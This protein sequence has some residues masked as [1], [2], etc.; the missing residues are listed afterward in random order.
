MVLLA[1]AHS[2]DKNG[3]AKIT[4]DEIQEVLPI[5]RSKVAAGLRILSSL[6]VIDADKDRQSTYRLRDF[7]GENTWAK[8]PCRGLYEADRIK[9]LKDFKLRSKSEL[10]AMKLYFLFAS[11]RDTRLNETRLSHLK[12]SEYSG[13]PKNR[14][15]TAISLLTSLGL[16]YTTRYDRDDS[17][18]GTSHGYRLIH[19]EAYNHP[20]TRKLEKELSV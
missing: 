15:L 10:D 9:A 2:I 8:L 4:Y 7:G 6:E 17:E 13:I 1:V 14:V 20:G 11:R 19:L 12:I 5:S 16:I 3:V 18:N